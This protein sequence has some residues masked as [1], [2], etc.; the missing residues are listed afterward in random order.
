MLSFVWMCCIS[1]IALILIHIIKNFL[2]VISLGLLN[3]SWGI[4][5]SMQAP[6][7]PIEAEKRGASPSQFSPIFGFIH[8]ATAVTSPFMAK[9]ITRVGLG[10]VFKL[11]LS[12]IFMAAISFGCL[13]YVDDLVL[14]LTLAY[15][16][17]I[18]AGVG[19]AALWTAMLSLLLARCKEMI[20]QCKY[21]FTV[22]FFRFPNSSG[23]V[24]SLVDATFGLGFTVGPV[25]GSFLF[26]AGGFVT[27][28][29][30]T[31]FLLLVSCHM[32]WDSVTIIA[33]T[34][35]RSALFD[36]L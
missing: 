12:L 5:G 17:R 31:G 11:S 24:Y 20:S 10:N 9:V 25:L 34:V 33:I 35:F 16:L 32:T 18:L 27:P 7:F 2:A 23:K 28:F 26:V 30:V 15:V 29:I 22:S 1:D 6:F 3:L 4:V 36:H 19:G 8:L 13:T 14:F 21:F